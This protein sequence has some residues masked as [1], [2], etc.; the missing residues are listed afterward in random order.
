[1]PDHIHLLLQPEIESDLVKF[2]QHYK[3]W[4]TRQA[5]KHG[6]QGKLWQRSFYDHILR[7]GDDLERHLRYIIENPVRAGIV[8]DWREF[9]Y[10][11]SLVY[12]LEEM[13]W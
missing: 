1:M 3:S 2:I 12:D 7:N 10:S 6:I 11:G 4:T 9:P 8:D 5:W 13:D